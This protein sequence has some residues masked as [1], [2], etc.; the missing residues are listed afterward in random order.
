[1]D[2]LFDKEPVSGRLVL[3]DYQQED[4]N[5]SF[6]LWDSGS[7]G[8]LTRAW[9][10]AGK[11]VMAC[12]K[13][14]TWLDR[15]DDYYV[16]VISYEQELVNQFAE[17]VSD[18]LGI[19][20]GIEMGEQRIRADRVPRVVVASRQSLLVSKP[21]NAK[22]AEVLKEEFGI[23]DLDH[24]TE[25]VGEKFL[26]FLRR[27]GDA[28]RVRDEIQSIQAMPEASGP[29]WSRLYKFDWRKNWLI[30]PDEAHRH[31]YKLQ[32]VRNWVDWFDQN[33]L[34]KRSGMTATPKRGDG[35]SIGDKMF[36]QVSIDIPLW[37]VDS[38][39]GVKMGW[40]VPYVQKYIQVEG[41]DFKA[42]RKVAGDFDDAELE[43]KLGQEK[44][45]ARLVEPLLDLVGDRQ[46]LIF[47]PGVKMAANVALYINARTECL[48]DK[49]NKLGW[50][51]VGLLG[52]GAAC[53]HCEAP[54][55]KRHIVKEGEQ[56][57]TISGNTDQ[58]DRQKIYRAHKGKIFQFLSVCGLCKEGY[59]DSEISCVAMFRPVSEKASSSAEQMKGRGGRPLKEIL[60]KLSA[61]TSDEERRA[62]IRASAK[63]FCLIVDLVG[64]TGLADCAST[65]LIYAE[66]LPDEVKERARK[67]LLKRGHDENA[68]VE[69]AVKQA[70]RE[71][72]EEKDKEKVEREH[73]E[74][75]RK[76]D[77]EKR[78]K[79]NPVVTYT[80]HERGIGSEVEH[81]F[82]S[83]GQMKFIAFMGMEVTQK[84]T[85]RR[86][87]RI[88]GMLKS[89]VPLEKVAYENSLREGQWSKNGPTGPQLNK[90][91]RCGLQDKQPS[92]PYEASL[93]IDAKEANHG[94]EF[95]KKMRER[96]NRAQNNDDIAAI[97]H[98]LRYVRG[99]LRLDV[100]N[101]LVAMAMQ[102]KAQINVNE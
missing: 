66:G 48:C 29:G 90:L 27:G 50:Y 89:R 38:R 6:Q 78:A 73:A 16:M 26:S 40:A 36:P 82:A 100:F 63:P 59:N 28:D 65:V 67:I 86:A 75:K 58:R 30:V 85:K 92:T 81:G 14:R 12:A 69:E 56:A 95:G 88:I 1:M 15:G 24:V 46:T 102:R 22:T 79:A 7:C 37:S 20:P 91:R 62:I 101:D 39:C 41:V 51:P 47:S 33:P 25:N 93:L 74:R 98:D 8:V 71:I 9:T 23:T 53:K 55:E 18:F 11:T 83:E 49:C 76:E 13:I 43:E 2:T 10:G 45:L 34:S 42:L 84:I 87:S 64:C 3:R 96:I 31:A 70:Q 97:G 52:D 35:V 99:V 60:A 54:L 72:D 5:R 94:V 80:V 57:R 77:A 68:D 32:S 17:E 44:V 4:H 21:V 19:T 61:A